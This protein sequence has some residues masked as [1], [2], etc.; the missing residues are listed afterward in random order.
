GE[1]GDARPLALLLRIVNDP[2]HV[3]RADAVEAVG[4]M[5]R[6]AK[7]HEIRELLEDLARGD[8]PVAGSAL[9]GLRWLDHPDGWQ[10]IRRRAADPRSHLQA[11]AVELLGYN[12]DPATRDLLPRLLA[13]SPDSWLLQTARAS[14][15]RLWGADSLEPDYAAVRNVNLEWDEQDALFRR[16]QER[17]DARRMLEVLPKVYDEAAGRLKGIL[18]GRQPLPVA[19][20]QTVVAGHD[21][22][23]AGVA[24]HLLGPDGPA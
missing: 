14:A 24:A 22:A 17:G 19:E 23:A 2:E 7:V 20:A 10:L 1:L 5:G 15:R 9:R 13:E 8:G 6:S 18:L 4:R 21:A 16:L 11:V 3:L 12:D